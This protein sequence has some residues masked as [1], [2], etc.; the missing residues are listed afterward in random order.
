VR[1][2]ERRDTTLLTGA[3]DEDGGRLHHEQN[4]HGA[5]HSRRKTRR[6][7]D[8][9]YPLEDQAEDRTGDEHTQDGGN[10]PRDAMLH[11]QR[12]EQV[13]RHCCQSA[14]GEVEQARSSVGQDEPDPREGIHR[15][16][17][18]SGNDEWEQRL[19][20]FLFRYAAIAGP[21]TSREAGGPRRA[22]MGAR[23]LFDRA[24][25]RSVSQ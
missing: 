5:H 25:S 18:Q 19:V 12:V 21:V 7:H 15:P 24:I 2:Q 22:R 9:R 13:G 14:V 11:V 20:V 3:V 16:R 8:A 4:A 6:R 17:R 23:V 10:R 1:R